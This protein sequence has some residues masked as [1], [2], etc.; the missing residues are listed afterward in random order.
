MVPVKKPHEIEKMRVACKKAALV[1]EKMCAL[2]E[3]GVNTYDLDQAARGFM[4]ELD[5]ESA[6][7]NYPNS[8]GKSRYPSYTCIS[9]NE[10]VVHGIG[11][12]NRI[13]KKGDN[14]TLDVVIKSDGF[15][16][17]NARTLL[18]EPVTSDMTFLVKTTQ[19]ALFIGIE[20]AKAGNRVGDIS[21]AVQRF[22]ESRKLSVVREFVGHGVGRT[23]HEEP[24]VPNYGRKGKGELLKPGMT[25]AIEPMVNMGSHEIEI[26]AD[27]WTA[28][29]RDR[30]PAAHFEH[31]VLITENGPEILTLLGH[32]V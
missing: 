18:L 21:N 15:L 6:C 20:H 17:D 27:G 9:V 3:P 5:C 19:E 31:T 29:T 12:I 4:K 10:E 25:I 22:V 16:G 32:K 14:I 30:L 8:K 23:M 2:V 7:L 24:Q 11:R 1:L 28:V 13:L 26:S